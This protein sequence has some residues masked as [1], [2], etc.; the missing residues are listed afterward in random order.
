ML[1]ITLCHGGN[2]SA[3]G[4]KHLLL[5]TIKSALIC[6]LFEK[7]RALREVKKCKW[8]AEEVECKA[9]HAG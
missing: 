6:F 3:T 9:K 5:Q 8:N 1:T 4:G 7:P 2:F